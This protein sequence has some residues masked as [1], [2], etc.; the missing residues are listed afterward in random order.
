MAGYRDVEVTAG[1][2]GMRLDRWLSRRFADRSRSAFSIAIKAGQVRSPEGRVFDCAYRVRAGE[3]LRLFVPG[4]APGTEPPP[5]PEILWEGPDLVA[6]DKPAGLLAHPAGTAFTWAVISLAKRRYPDERVDLVHRL[7]R[8]TSGVLVL[9]RNLEANRRLKEQV[10]RGDVYKEYHALVKGVVPWDHADLD[11][12]IGPADGLIRVQ[13][14][15]RPDGLPAW[16][17][18]DVLER[19]QTMTRVRCVLHTGRTHQIRVHL[20]HAGFPIVGDRLYGVP[21]ELFLKIR[22]FG[23]DDG[24]IAQAG[25]PRH[26]LHA[27]RVVIP[28]DPPLELVAPIPADMQRWWSDPGRLPLDRDTAGQEVP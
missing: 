11:G 10:A 28:G 1:S 8:D 3:V 22:D 20:A 18:V 13:M 12:P 24:S 2:S 25:A 26:A 7:D 5:F 21:P 14:G 17:E 16:T 23:L 6:V 19:G 27:R 15:V 4:I 9:T